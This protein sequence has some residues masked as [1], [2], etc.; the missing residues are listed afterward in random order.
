V[1]ALGGERREAMYALLARHFEGVT[2]EGFAADLAEKNWA[3]LFEQDGELVGF[4]TLLLYRAEHAGEA[5][6]IVYS[7]DTIVDPAAWGTTALPRSWITAVRRLHA[8]HGVGRLY[9]LLIT[10]GFRTYRFLPVF[11]RD[12]HPRHDAA[13]PPEVA[14]LRDVLARERFGEAYDAATGLVRFARP[15]RLRTHLAGVPEERRAD[16]HVAH[17]E[18]LNPGHAEGDELVCLT[19]LS[20]E[21][22][23]RA[24]WRMV[25]AGAAR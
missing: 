7:G 21:N 20:D 24:G 15:Q 12:F 11:W 8:E 22:L 14:A 25:R 1:A 5:L 6:T 10:S 16:P 2:P 9:W 17:F 13:M 4:S 3:L 19:E 23:T 18:R